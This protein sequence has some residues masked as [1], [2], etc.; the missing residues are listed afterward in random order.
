MRKK[1]ILLL[2]VS[3]LV[4]TFLFLCQIYTSGKKEVVVKDKWFKNPDKVFFS[5]K[6]KDLR[7][8]FFCSVKKSYLSR[9]LDLLKDRSIVLISKDNAKE[10]CSSNINLNAGNTYLIRALY[11]NNLTGGY[12]VTISGDDIWISN[13]YF[14]QGNKMN[15]DAVVICCPSKLKNLFVTCSRVE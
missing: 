5:N 12:I 13:A 14:G 4:L 15:R 1:S 8:D 2:V 10:I 11:V 7:K 6:R 3:I 9:S